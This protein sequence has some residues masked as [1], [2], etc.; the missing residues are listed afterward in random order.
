MCHTQSSARIRLRPRLPEL[1]LETEPLLVNLKPLFVLT[2]ALVTLS[3]ASIG[4]TSIYVP[5]N[6]AAVGTCNVIPFGSLVNFSAGYTYVGRIPATFL[7]PANPL[8]K[9]I[10]F[11]PCSPGNWSCSTVIMGVGHLPSGI[12]SMT[13]PDPTISA[14][15]T[16][17]DFTVIWDSN[18][19]GPFSWNVTANTFSPMGF[20]AGGGTTF[21]WDGTNDIGFYVSYQSSVVTG[22]AGDF[23]RTGTEPF[24]M[25]AAGF[26]APASTGTGPN[27]LK[28]QLD[29]DPQVGPQ[30]QLDISTSGV[31]DGSL[32]LTN[33]PTGTFSGWTFITTT[34]PTPVGGGPAL[35]ITPDALTF[36]I[37]TIAPVAMPGNPFHWTWPVVGIFPDTAIGAPAGTFTPFM[38]QTWD[39]VS[40]AIDLMG[41][42]NGASNVDRVTW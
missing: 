10:A 39:F 33:I 11:T 41:N 3:P 22:F 36:T 5:D 23:H 30:F 9:E 28:M 26:L 35:G 29:F 16:F 24:R 18:V 13:F 31:G 19:N 37:L 1:D 27:G 12:T 4:Q 42:L 21:V 40:L 15:G 2:L 8:L 38:G 25:Y 14:N 6:Q 32:S 20:A 17:L 34:T 7:D